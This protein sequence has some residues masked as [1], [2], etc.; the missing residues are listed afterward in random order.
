MRNVSNV[1]NM[2][3][4]IVTYKN[5]NVRVNTL[6]RLFKQVNKRRWSPFYSSA[7]V[8]VT[9][10][11]LS[12]AIRAQRVL[13]RKDHSGTCGIQVRKWPVNTESGRSTSVSSKMICSKKTQ[14]RWEIRIRGGAGYLHMYVSLELELGYVIKYQFRKRRKL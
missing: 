14:D 3:V 9:F 6:T 2:F 1:S 8:P 13:L 5:E 11:V 4:C 12:P 7:G 10:T